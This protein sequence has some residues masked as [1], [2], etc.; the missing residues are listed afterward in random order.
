[1]AEADLKESQPAAWTSGSVEWFSIEPCCHKNARVS[2]SKKLA[3]GLVASAMH[4]CAPSPTVRL[5]PSGVWP[6]ERCII[7]T[8]CLRSLSA[9]LLACVAAVPAQ[10][11]WGQIVDFGAS[12]ISVTAGSSVDFWV[13]Y[14]VFADATQLSGGS[15]VGKEPPP[16]DGYQTWDLNWYYTT[17]EYITTVTVNAGGQSRSDYFAPAPGTG[18]SGGWGFS[19]AFDVPGVY[20]IDASGSWESWAES[21]YS[22]ETASRNCW[23]NDP[24]ARDVLV[25][26]SWTYEY[27]DQTDSFTNGG[28]LDGR[29]LT[30]SVT[31]VPELATWLMWGAGLASLV[32][33]RLRR[34]RR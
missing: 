1:M 34:Q 16:Q 18:Q 8:T 33:R 10:A 24:D 29:S 6:L 20:Q 2:C 12:A 22:S 3:S 27:H 7:E 4:R 32:S 26:D 31:A 13:S 5:R 15:N 21:Y 11:G 28:G 17:S 25:C 14:N 9:G 30:I 19:I 23:Y